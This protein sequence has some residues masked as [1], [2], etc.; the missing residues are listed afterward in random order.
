[1][2]NGKP[3]KE[4]PENAGVE[5]AWLTAMLKQEIQKPTE[6]KDEDLKDMVAVAPKSRIQGLLQDM[7]F[8]LVDGLNETPIL[9]GDEIIG[10]PG[11]DLFDGWWDSMDLDNYK[12]TSKLASSLNTILRAIHQTDVYGSGE[13]K[14]IEKQLAKIAQKCIEEPMYVER[15]KEAV[16]DLYPGIIGEFRSVPT[17]MEVNERKVI[18][19]EKQVNQINTQVESNINKYTNQLAKI[20]QAQKTDFEKMAQDLNRVVIFGEAL[21]ELVLYS[22][23]SPHAPRL[24]INN[25][26]YRSNLHMM[27]AG[28]ISTAKSKILKLSKLIAP[29]AL[30]VD[31]T[32]KASYEGIGKVGGEIEDGVLDH[33]N[34]GAIIVEEFTSPFARMS[35]FRRAMDCETITIYKV[36]TSKVIDVNTT[37]VTACNPQDDF[38]QEETDF[39]KQLN[40]KEGI[41]SRF[42]ILIPLT[43]TT[44]KNEILL[45]KLDIMTPQ[46]KLGDRVID[47]SA[48]KETLL[49]ISQGMSSITRV[50]ITP[51]QSEMMKDAFRSRNDMDKYRRVLKNRPLVILRDLE[52]LARL[53]NIITAVNF[54][55]R[56]ISNGV[57]QTDDD[58][59]EKAIQLWENLMQLRIQLYARHDRNLKSVADEIITYVYNRQGLDGGEVDVG[60]VKNYIVDEQ[61]LVGS[62]TFYKEIN[63]LE[64]TGRLVVKG[65]RDKKLSVVVK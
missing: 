46:V 13:Q 61:R 7:Y 55:K 54:S 53:V 12:A 21:W 26:D 49:T 37:M 1:M 25:M 16:N 65:K 31:E 19:Y 38:F 36:G 11:E 34:Q 62:V 51:E 5:K 23:M 17:S 44:V 40:F 59:V 60:L 45:D 39:R 4:I 30:I 10:Q 64:E 29:K 22:L 24:I 47:F 41:L 15:L 8:Y 48:I 28:D 18:E 27:L 42:D 32:T 50:V 2:E 35:L 6:V 33:A 3:K 20:K 52:T 43:A 63:T 58:D 57:V 14:Q 56:V 9:H